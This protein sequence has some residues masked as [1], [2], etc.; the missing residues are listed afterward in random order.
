M[1]NTNPDQPSTY[2]ARDTIRDLEIFRRKAIGNFIS[3]GIAGLVSA[4]GLV[5]LEITP[6]AVSWSSA[7]E[8]ATPGSVISIV[9]VVAC[10]FFYNNGLEN[11]D[12]YAEAIIDAT[13]LHQEINQETKLN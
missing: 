6:R 10:A 3:S 7:T 5:L 2:E 12:D 11:L 8:H 1:E 9:G 4:S 13:V